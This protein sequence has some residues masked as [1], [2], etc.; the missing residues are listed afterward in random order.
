MEEWLLLA[1]YENNF[2]NFLI[3]NPEA[4][5]IYIYLLTM[6]K[7]KP[8]VITLLLLIG[9]ALTFWLGSRYPT[10]NEKALMGGGADMADL[11]F[12]KVIAVDANAGTLERVFVVTL[13]WAE[14]NKK[15]MTFG[16]LFASTILTLISLI[17]QR[18]FNKTWANTLLGV[19]IGA[20]LGVCVNCAAPIAKGMQSGGLRRETTLAAMISSPTL[21]VVILTMLFALFPWY[22]ATIKVVVTLLFILIGIPLIARISGS[23]FTTGGPIKPK[24]VLGE[25]LILNR[26]TVDYSEETMAISSWLLASKWVIIHLLKNLWYIIKTTVPLM[27]LAGILGA[28]MITILP[29]NELV[30]LVSSGGMIK[31]FFLLILV[32]VFGILLPVPIAFDVIIAAILMAAGM[33]VHFVMALLFTLGVFSVYSFFVVSESM[34]W[35]LGALLLA[36]LSF[37]GM[38]SGVIANKTEDYFSEKQRQ[39]LVENFI[40]DNEPIPLINQP[41]EAGMS[42]EA[43]SAELNQHEM[44]YEVDHELSQDGSLY[45]LSS[46]SF[47]NQPND[48]TSWRFEKKIGDEHGISIPYYLSSLNIMTPFAHFRST[49]AADVHNDGWE[50]ILISNREWLMLYANV[51]GTYKRQKLKTDIWDSVFFLN[52]AFSDFNNDGWQDI[53]FSTYID[54]NYILYNQEG[55]FEQGQLVKLPSLEESGITTAPGFADIDGNGEMDIL[56][57]NWSAGPWSRDGAMKSSQNLILYQREGQFI[58]EKLDGVNGETLSTLIVDWNDDGKHDIAIGNDFNPPEQFYESTENGLAKVT[59][60]FPVSTTTTMSITSADIDNDLKEELLFSQVSNDN[61]AKHL[62]FRDLCAELTGTSYYENC[63]LSRD[64]LYELFRAIINKRPSFCEGITDPALSQDCKAYYML[65]SSQDFSLE[66]L[67]QAFGENWPMHQRVVDLRATAVMADRQGLNGWKN[68][69]SSLM[70][71]SVL[72]D[73]VNGS[74]TNRANVAGVSKTGWSWNTEFADLDN[75]GWQDLYV[76]NG[77]HINTNGSRVSNIFYKNTGEGNFRDETES[78]GLGLF[79]ESISYVY[80]DKDRDGDLDIVLMP[81]FGPAWVFENFGNSNHSVSFS[82]RDFI[83]NRSAIGAKIYIDYDEDN[84]FDQMRQ[85]RSSGGFISQNAPDALFGLGSYSSIKKIKVIWPSGEEVVFDRKLQADK[86]YKI[87]RK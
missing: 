7:N 53:Y 44:P 83:S 1:I 77:H 29:W 24:R 80:T 78:T 70:D 60:T 16:I 3:D 55:D 56:L 79:Q 37:L 71:E 87:L 33:P 57:G 86:A 20:P 81:Q 73:Y 19:V 10:L 62:P 41:P 42:L 52:A 65:Y 26:F 13:N 54:G 50:D 82:L 84:E 47:N 11:G 76:A 74:W 8:F 67:N 12:D 32:A 38:V 23:F 28:I 21:N 45:S 30:Y 9:L 25:D 6:H 43:L 15:G 72:L 63:Q 61:N 68:E 2:P 85:I 51:G 64:Y 66:E 18:E 5:F 36:S 40:S 48:Q 34:S 59:R 4:N 35:K 58:Q 46:T 22:I 27:L 31:Q 39:F 14:T 17:K 49:A 69:V 75:D